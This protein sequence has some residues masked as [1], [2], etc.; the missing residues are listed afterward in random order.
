ML[1]G[2][3]TLRVNAIDARWIDRW[4]LVVTLGMFWRW[5]LTCGFCRTRFRKDKFVAGDSAE[6]PVC[7]T[8]NLL[9]V[10][11]F[12]WDPGPRPGD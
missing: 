8:R 9:P 2:V 5:E 11:R 10:P 4:L 1:G 3:G 6:C 12:P 7:G